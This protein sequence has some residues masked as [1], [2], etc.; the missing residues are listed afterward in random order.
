[1]QRRGAAP[2]RDGATLS[3]VDDACLLN[4]FRYLAPLPDLFAAAAVCRVRALRCDSAITLCATSALTAH[5]QRW[6]KVAADSRLRLVIGAGGA[7]ADAPRVPWGAPGWNRYATLAAAVAASQPGQGIYVEAGEHAL[8]DVHIR[9]AC[10][11]SRRAV[12]LHMRIL[13]SR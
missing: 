10:F 7:P 8:D 3:C 13:I 11:A 1:M 5:Q 9:R 2:A 4:I 12:A 6:H